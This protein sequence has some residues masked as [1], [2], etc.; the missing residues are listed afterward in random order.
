M[1]R[2]KIVLDSTNEFGTRLTTPATQFPRMV[3]AEFN[4]HKMI[5]KNS[6]SSRAIPFEKMLE[7]VQN[8]PFIPI[9]WM[10]EHKGMQGFEYFTDEEVKELRLYEDHLLARDYAIERAMNQSAKGLTKQ[11]VNRYL[12]PFM[13]HKVL[14][15]GTEWEN[16]LA[17]RAA[18]GAEIHI[19]DL[20][21]KLLD[22][23]NAST[24][25]MLKA[26]EWH[27]P[28]GDRIDSNEIYELYKKGHKP[29][30]VTDDF[31][32]EM[33]LKI[34]T[35]RCARTSY[36]N[37]D[38]TSDFIKDIEL[39]DRLVEGGHWSPM[40]HSARC[41]TQDEFYTY[42]KTVII[43]TKDLDDYEAKHSDHPDWYE[44]NNYTGDHNQNT[45]LTEF[46]WCKNFRGFI[47][48]RHLFSNENRREPR[49]NRQC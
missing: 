3:L 15:T 44:I 6:A 2:A 16:F 31:I 10:K 37:F 21:Y 41:M 38:G 46:G 12:E 42:S 48:Y 43:P 33:E 7:K 22:V 25:R 36:D 18:E 47:S 4:T 24:P 5:S 20:A 26:G 8:D 19:Q 39:H 49:L 13:Y 1:I 11:I 32:C 40:E 30:Q 27:I 14:A 9:K 29:G 45:V 34:A 17:L 35:A 28:F 23:M